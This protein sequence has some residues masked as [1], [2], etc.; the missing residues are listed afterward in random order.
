MPPAIDLSAVQRAFDLR[1]SESRVLVVA[2]A[3]LAIMCMHEAGVLGGLLWFA[4][5]MGAFTI[6][7]IIFREILE[8][9]DASARAEWRIGLVLGAITAAFMVAALIL[10]ADP[11]PWTSAA[12]ASILFITLLNSGHFAAISRRVFF[13]TIAP[14]LALG[15]MLPVYAAIASLGADW[16]SVILMAVLT[17]AGMGLV[18]YHIQQKLAGEAALKRVLAQEQVQQRLTSTVLDLDRRCIILLD[19]ES[20]ILMASPSCALLFEDADG[21]HNGC[22]LLDVVDPALRHWSVALEDAIDGELTR[23]DADRVVFKNGADLYL[24][25]EARPWVDDEG[26]VAGALMFVEDVTE[27]QIAKRDAEEATQNLRMALRAANAAVWRLDFVEETMWASPEY[28]E[29]LGEAP[30]YADFASRRPS[31]LLEE[32]FARY[33]EMS[34]SL[35]RPNGRA[36]IEHRLRTPNDAP[37]WVHSDMEAVFDES[38]RPRW[39]IGMTRN[40][41]QRRILEA[42]LMEA[43]RQ[44]EATLVSKRSILEGL[45]GDLGAAESLGE[46][47][48]EHRDSRVELEEL[49]E[50]FMRVLGE[51]DLRDTLLAESVEALRDARETAE[52]ANAAKSH[53]L[54]SMSHELRTPLNAIIGYSELL[55]EEMEAVDNKAAAKDINRILSAA[56]RLLSLINGILDLSK[57]EAG[58][59]ELSLAAFSPQEMLN[60]TVETMRPL[61]AK[62]GNVI[63][64]SFASDLGEGYSDAFRIGQC[65]LNLISNA[66]KFTESG[67]TSATAE[68]VRD[69]D[70]DWLVFDVTD[71]GIG[72]DGE[73]LARL[74]QPFVQAS[75]STA[76]RYGGTGLGLSITRRL[77]EVLGGDLSVESAPG[78]GSTFTLRVPARLQDA[79][80]GSLAAPAPADVGEGPAILVI[81]DHSDAR[82][83]VRRAVARLGMRVIEAHGLTDGL[84]AARAHL[85]ALIVLDIHL[86]D[87]DGWDVLE[88]LRADATLRDIPCVVLSI[89]DD[90]ARAFELGACQHLLKPIDRETLATTVLQFARRGDEAPDADAGALIVTQWSLAG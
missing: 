74:F 78:K 53:F 73:Q 4:V 66:C 51:I 44:A 85:P 7:R 6:E 29:L 42:R 1:Q 3:L 17:I 59:M 50:R 81:D 15:P 20:R 21:A 38:G 14:S 45:V 26:R 71:T 72:M 9:G 86:D 27:H 61:A 52:A 30:S 60:E 22:A 54:A 34:R 65:L 63:T 47:G 41:T 57:I 79:S 69:N 39:I 49:F 75:S 24:R 84:D 31:W 36:T 5:T 2:S 55:L 33:E 82:E 37:L 46:H 87:G 58:R 32:D 8:S 70:L 76:S 19:R 68:R 64:V 83:L 80:S 90:R 10:M 89:N 43:T 13:I 16:T 25:W 23:V 11:R 35:M 77:S 48:A 18:L 62:N 56:R 12:S 28:A 67:E 40:I 88:E